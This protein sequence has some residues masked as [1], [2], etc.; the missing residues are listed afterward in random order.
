[1]NGNETSG[2]GEFYR[3]VF[4][5]SVDTTRTMIINLQKQ[6]EFNTLMVTSAL[7]GEGKSTLSCH[8]AISFARAGRK[9]LLIDADLRS[10][11]VHEVFQ[12]NDFPGMCEAIRNEIPVE[13]CIV[14]TQVPRLSLL[15]AGELDN[16]TLRMLAEDRVGE[17]LNELREHYDMIILDS[18]PVLP[19]ADTLLLLQ[20]VDGI[21]LSI[22]KDVTRISK[23]ASALSKLEMLG[24][25]L[26]GAVVIGIDEDDY[27][28]R[29]KYIRNYQSNMRNQPEEMESAVTG[30]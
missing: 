16:T 28:Y 6:Q 20:S 17:L 21:V 18:A 5:E 14:P 12:L 23:L 22:R 19:V 15:P 13:K 7:G 1:M 30:E 10:P 29:S 8:L 27:G 24:G 11:R 4:A 9:T 2:K 26:F 3:H 25:N